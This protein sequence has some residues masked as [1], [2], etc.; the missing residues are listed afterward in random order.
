MQDP[1][2]LSGPYNILHQHFSIRLSIQ[3]IK[4][5]GMSPFALMTQCHMSRCFIHICFQSSIPYVGLF[6]KQIG[7]NLYHQVLSLVNIL[8]I[9]VYVHSQRITVFFH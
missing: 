2:A 6:R 1:V 3:V 7:K 5:E 4:A 8:Q 9:P